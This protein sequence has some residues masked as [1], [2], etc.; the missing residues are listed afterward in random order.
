MKKISRFFALLLVMFMA[1]IC[2][3]VY[4]FFS[5]EKNTVSDEL[6][7]REYKPSAEYVK[8]LGRTFSDEKGLLLSYSGSGI[9][10]YCEG[11]YAELTLSPFSQGMS[12]DRAPRYAV[13][14]DGKTVSDEVLT[15][16]KTLRINVL[17]EGSVVR[18]VK[19][20]EAMYSSFYVDSVALYGRKDIQPTEKKDLS[21]E[22][23]GDSMTCGYGI[24]AG[25]VGY[26][27]TSTENFAKTYAYLTAENLGADYSAICYSGYGVYSGYTSDGTR[28]HSV[29]LPEYEKAYYG[30]EKGSWSFEENQK[31]IT[32]INLGTNDASYCSGSAYLRGQ[33]IVAYKELLSAVREKN[34]DTLILCILGDM[35]NSMF[36]SIEKAVTEFQSETGDSGV[37][38]FTV[39]FKMGEND[40]VIDGHPGEKSNITAAENLTAKIREIIGG[41]F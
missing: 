30:D 39:D 16:E 28:N 26:F 2:I 15:Q 27:K 22:F 17:Q 14:V 35:N 32:V 33:F 19:L 37:Y 25:S 38:A 13:S 10:F 4:F 36:S 29:L 34:P 8:V 40:I 41:T 20:S 6:L 5:G 23:I 31:V 24:D 11:V 1:F 21:I 7:L 18:L 9:E 12:E 3:S